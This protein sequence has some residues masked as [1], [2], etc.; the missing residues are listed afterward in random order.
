MKGITHN[1]TLLLPD[2]TVSVCDSLSMCQ[3]QE[4]ISRLMQNH[5]DRKRA[6]SEHVVYNLLNPTRR[7]ASRLLRSVVQMKKNEMKKNDSNE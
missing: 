2:G 6:V 1:L 4:T 5:Y 7:R 3:S